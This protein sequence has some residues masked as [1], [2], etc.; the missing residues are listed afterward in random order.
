[1]VQIGHVRMRVGHRLVLVR[2]RVPYRGR[3]PRVY[4]RVV[5]VIVAVAMRVSH[6]LVLMLMLMPRREH[7]VEPC[8]YARSGCKLRQVDLLSKDSPGEKHA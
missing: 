5:S 8:G 1:M 6:G 3:Q 7:E 2:M 4:V